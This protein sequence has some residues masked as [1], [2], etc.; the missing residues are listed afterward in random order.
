ME[1][2]PDGRREINWDG[3]SDAVA[4]PNPFPP[5]FFN[6]PVGGSPRGVV[7]FTPGTSFLVSANKEN[8]TNAKIEFGDIKERFIQE[9]ATFSLQRLSIS[10]QN[11]PEL[12]GKQ[13]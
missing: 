9:F 5:N 7:L 13:R 1:S 11:Y 6:D 3:V 4:D 2:F 8:P 12:S 10:V